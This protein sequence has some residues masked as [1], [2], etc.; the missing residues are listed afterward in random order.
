[1]QNEKPAELSLNGLSDVVRLAAEQPK[2]SQ[3]RRTQQESARAAEIASRR[4]HL[5]ARRSGGTLAF[6]EVGLARHYGRLARF[7]FRGAAQ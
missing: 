2:D 5:T 6:A 7:G 1:M 3:S 4:H